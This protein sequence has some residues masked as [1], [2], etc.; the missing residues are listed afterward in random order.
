MCFWVAVQSTSPT[1]L[2]QRRAKAEKEKQKKICW[3]SDHNDQEK[4]IETVKRI[5]Q[6]ELKEFVILHTNNTYIYW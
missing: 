6:Y 4:E 2:W 1:H 3:W 5:E